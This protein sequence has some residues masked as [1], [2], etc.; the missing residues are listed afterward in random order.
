MLL[1]LLLAVSVG[2]GCSIPLVDVN[3]ERRAGRQ[4]YD[5]SS[6]PVAR[7]IELD[8]TPLPEGYGAIFVPAMSDPDDEPEVI[9]LVDDEEVASGGTGQRIPVPAGSYTVRV[10]SGSL[11]QAVPVSAYVNAGETLLVP[12]EWGGLIIEV[13]DENNIPHRGDYELIRVSDREVVG[14]GFGADTL[15]GE[16]LRTWLLE[17]GLYRI[18][19]PGST[20]RARTDFATVYVPEGAL[21]RYKL[22]LDPLT[23]DFRGAGVVA[24]D[25]MST[26]TG[27]TPWTRRVVLG[28]TAG[29]SQND[30]VVGQANQLTLSADLFL[31]TFVSYDFSSHFF[32][33]I[34]ELEEGIVHVDPADSEALPLQLSRDRLRI[35]LIYTYFI[36]DWIGP[37]L[38]L[39]TIASLFPARVIATEDFTIRRQFTDGFQRDDFV[40]GGQSFETSG[41]IGSVQLRQGIGVNIRFLRT[42]QADAKFRVGAGFRQNLFNDSF[43]E[44]DEAETQV[45]EYRQLENFNEEGIE[46]VLTMTM[47]FLRYLTYT[48]EAELFADFDTFTDPTISWQNTVSFRF[49]S[50]AALDYTL[51]LLRQPQVTDE[52][53]LSQNVLLRLA[54]EIL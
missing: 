45:I 4:L 24:P 50:F 28:I 18:V 14:I 15:L 42:T 17:D 43:V 32:N 27:V 13:V 12:V 53:Q 1:A 40:E 6:P 48:T 25:E 39:G 2:A 8:R 22:V 38:A 52:L 11:S 34:V 21:V 23:G 37:Y 41:P 3:A 30:G 33:A 16:R 9:V 7:Q 10:G 35:D 36:T 47:R 49:T 44:E 51:D 54:W 31:D 5:W 46:S 20:Y 19:R 26:P 29:M